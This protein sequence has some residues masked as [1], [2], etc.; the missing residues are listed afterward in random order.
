MGKS[1]SKTNS[2]EYASDNMN[3]EVKLKREFGL[4]GGTCFIVGGM[5]GSGIFVSPVGILRET[6]SVGMSLIIWLLCAFLALG[7]SL[8]YAELGTMIPKSGGEYAY[9]LE[10]M[11]ALPA[12]LFSWTFTLVIR[13]A[14][15]AI[16]CLIMGTYTAEYITNSDCVDNDFLARIFAIMALLILTFINCTSVKAANQIQIWFTIAKLI[17]CAIIIVIGFIKIGKG[18]TEFINPQTSFKHSSPNGLSYAL[19][20]YQGLWAYE[21]W[22]F[23]N[24]LT[25]E[26]KNP[27][28]NLPLSLM[29][30]IPFVALVYICMNIAYFTVITPEEMLASKAVAVTFA[31]RTMGGF[32]WIVPVGVCMS[33]FGAANASLFT[34]GRLPFVAARE[35]HMAQILGMVHA[36]RLTPQPA[37]MSVTAIALALICIGDFNGLLNYFSFAVWLFYSLTVLSLMMMRYTHSHWERPI[38][39]PIVIPI[40]FFCASLYLIFAPII[41]TP[42]IEFLY[43]FIFIVFGILVFFAFVWY[44]LQVKGMDSM[45]KFL[46][47]L[48]YVIPTSYNGKDDEQKTP[49]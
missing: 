45:T 6:E 9:L 5:I 30:G 33:T 22:S 25:E 40:I 29:I 48:L 20:F 42:E 34:A 15:V 4:F 16:V 35:G 31:H 46:Q 10:A 26:L 2:I 1:K 28:R 7:G 11:G 19:A 27:R 49:L 47:K 3:S 37:V 18:N 36:K 17:V 41:N 38:K 13:P 21:G 23:L 14:T 8:C 43:A 24:S 39:V 12:F 32:A 44:K